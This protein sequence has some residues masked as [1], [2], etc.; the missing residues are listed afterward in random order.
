MKTIDEH[1]RDAA[2]SSLRPRFTQR[3]IAQVRIEA[4]P[5]GE[6]VRAAL[7]CLVALAMMGSGF[8]QL[9]QSQRRSPLDPAAWAA[10]KEASVALK[11]HL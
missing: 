10:F 11:R 6:V 8:W 9:T 4:E 1:I 3:V 2:R 5:R 7:A